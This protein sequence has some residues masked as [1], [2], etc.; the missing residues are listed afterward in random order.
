MCS[1]YIFSAYNNIKKIVFEDNSG[2]EEKEM[3]EKILSYHKVHMLLSERVSRVHGVE[4]EGLFL[5]SHRDYN[6]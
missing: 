4:D 3:N 1:R 2:R 6:L 5:K